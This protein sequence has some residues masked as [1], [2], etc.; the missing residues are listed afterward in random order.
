MIVRNGEMNTTSHPKRS[1]TPNN[2]P[3]QT[4]L[5][6]MAVNVTRQPPPRESWMF[7]AL[8]HKLPIA[9]RQSAG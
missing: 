5:R 7:R 8:A 1:R 6:R 9:E 3:W 4:L 2:L